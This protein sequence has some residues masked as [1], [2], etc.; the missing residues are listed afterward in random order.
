MRDKRAY[1]RPEIAVDGVTDG[2]CMMEQTSLT[3]DQD[4]PWWRV[5]LGDTYLVNEITIF[6]RTDTD[7]EQLNNFTVTLL[8]AAGNVVWKSVQKETP[9]PPLSI[10]VDSKKG[11]FVKVQLNG[12]G[13]LALAEVIV[14]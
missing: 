11:R 14:K 1:P 8:D 12:K 4:K 3:K 10:P 9:K 2:D 5:D 6:N 13:T 7:I